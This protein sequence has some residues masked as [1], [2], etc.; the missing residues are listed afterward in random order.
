[1]MNVKKNNEGDEALRTCPSDEDFVLGEI[2][3]SSNQPSE[4][5]SDS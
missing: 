4:S 3:E 5:E 1:M 2:G